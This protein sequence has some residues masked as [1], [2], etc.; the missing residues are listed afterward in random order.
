MEARDR[1]NP[2]SS[3]EEL[4]AA[5]LLFELELCQPC[6]ASPMAALPLERD[7]IKFES[8]TQPGKHH[9]SQKLPGKVLGGTSASVLPQQAICR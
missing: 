9:V 2:A 7:V 8:P 4:L 3:A 5:W 1:Q 6:R